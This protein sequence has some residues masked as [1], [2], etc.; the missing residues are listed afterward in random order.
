MFVLEWGYPQVQNSCLARRAAIEKRDA[1]GPRSPPPIDPKHAA[2]SY[3][4]IDP[5]FTRFF[6][7]ARELVA[8]R[9]GKIRG[10]F[11]RVQMRLAGTLTNMLPWWPDLADA[12][13][14]IA[15]DGAY[16]VSRY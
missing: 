6:N 10:I 5:A 14:A 16:L 7:K 8:D 2:E 3:Q 4:A 9:Q 12:F 13:F 15:R 11:A 1:D